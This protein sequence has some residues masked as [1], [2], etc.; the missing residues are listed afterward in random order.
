ML[1]IRPDGTEGRWRWSHERYVESGQTNLDWVETEQGWQVYVKQF[2]DVSASRPPSTIW[3]HEEVGHNHLAADELKRLFGQSVFDNP[4]P[5]KLVGR[6]L[7][8]AT[9]NGDVVLD[10][11]AGSCT[12]AHGVLRRNF[13]TATDNRF[14]MV[15][16]PEPTGREDYPTIADIGKERIR[17]VIARMRTEGREAEGPREEA[18]MTL[19]GSVGEEKPREP[20][21][22]GF[23]V[24]KLGRS[25][26]RRWEPY[27]GESTAEVQRRFDAFQQP[28]VDGWQPEDLLLEI[29]LQE[30]FP[31]D[32]R[33]ESLDVPGANT[34]QRVAHEWCEHRLVVCLDRRVAS[35][36]A[37]ALPSLLAANDV[38]ICLDSALTDESKM[39]LTD[40][41]NLKVI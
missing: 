14:I 32:S 29:M 39:R 27:E 34:V 28:L 13:E 19:P 5:S 8:I 1:P 41:L 15:Q 37:E 40:R 22:L 10:F 18:Q 25:N 35:D 36:T 12:T 21:D 11:F 26:F 30:G 24:Y 9:D 23:R 16:L 33:V 7:E 20:E 38:F 17:R 3:H 31:L 4:K 2:H 6:M